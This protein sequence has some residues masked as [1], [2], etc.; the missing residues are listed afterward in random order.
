M[1]FLF[2]VVFLVALTGCVRSDVQSFA[3]NKMINWENRVYMVTDQQIENTDKLLGT[4]KL[5]SNKEKDLSRNYS[6]NFY[7][8]GT[9][10]YSIAGLDYKDSIAIQEDG[11]KYVKANSNK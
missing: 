2:P 6:S 4:I 3:S 9:A 1:K 7:S 8:V 11:D 5:K 10:V